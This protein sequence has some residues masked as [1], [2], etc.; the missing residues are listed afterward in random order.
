MSVA[1]YGKRP[2]KSCE[3]VSSTLCC[4]SRSAANGFE[5]SCDWFTHLIP[6]ERNPE[7]AR[8]S[9]ALGFERGASYRSATRRQFFSLSL[10]N[11][12]T[13]TH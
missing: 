11:M 5:A 6:Y 12:G 10:Q 13:F 3:R 1:A 7:K 2:Q 4:P 9:R 8:V